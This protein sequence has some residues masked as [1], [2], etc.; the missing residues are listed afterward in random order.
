MKKIPLVHGCRWGSNGAI[1]VVSLGGI[2][3][4]GLAGTVNIRRAMKA[5]EQLS[6]VATQVSRPP[7]DA[8]DVAL[9]V[10]A[11]PSRSPDGGAVVTVT[12]D[13]PGI[14]SK[15]VERVFARFARAGASRTA[16]ATV[17]LSA[18]VAAQ[19]DAPS[20]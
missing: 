6:E 15:F 13:G 12:D 18:G 2:V 14:P 11:R 19:G 10:R 17:W 1:S 3:V 4:I 9:A 5:L 16:L 20:S 8:G 7:L